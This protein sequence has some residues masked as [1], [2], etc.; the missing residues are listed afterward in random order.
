MKSPN[1]IFCS[2]LLF[3]AFSAAPIFTCNAQDDPLPQG[4]FWN[5]VR[6]GGGIGLGFGNGFFS[7]SLSPVAIY[8]FNEYFSF[9]AGLNGIYASR[10]DV[11]RSTILGGSLIALSN[12]YPSL[13]V[14]AEF[15]QLNV[16]QNFDENFVSNADRN[17]WYSALFIGAG[18]RVGNFITGIRYDVL[19]NE[20][21]S[22]YNSAWLP[23]VRVFF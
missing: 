22:I 23:F 8:D 16:D 2:I 18:Y 13:Q 6:F 1:S 7:G 11:S 17:Y 20:D 3:F 19:Y 5:N 21:R 10:R 12:P 15:E 4:S 9:G 14:S